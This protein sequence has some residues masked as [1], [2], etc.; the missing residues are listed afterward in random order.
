MSQAVDRAME[1]FW[2]TFVKRQLDEIADVVLAYKPP[3]KT[4]KA[5]K[6]PAKTKESMGKKRFSI[7]DVARIFNVPVRLLK[8]LRRG[9][10]TR[11]MD[12]KGKRLLKAKEQK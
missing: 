5:K 9:S 10:F 7:V 1:R 11:A 3:A 2:T 6:T 8:G 4:K 12:A